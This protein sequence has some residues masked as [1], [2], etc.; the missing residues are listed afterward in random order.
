MHAQAHAD[1][2]RACRNASGD[3]EGKHAPADFSLACLTG[4]EESTYAIA[5]ITVH[6]NELVESIVFAGVD[7]DSRRA[8]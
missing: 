4:E 6:G 3:V 7:I 1:D 8:R 5:A 2:R